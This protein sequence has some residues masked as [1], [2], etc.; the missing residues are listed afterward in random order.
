M[1][2][3]KQTSLFDVDEYTTTTKEWK[4]MPEFIQEDLHPYKTIMVHFE[5]YEDMQE[6]AKLLGITLT[7]DTK[8]TW[9]PQE[10]K[11]G[12]IRRYVDVE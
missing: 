7:I 3:E 4:N 11:T 8:S 5:K 2:E 12:V 10:E 1:A 6:F 9:F